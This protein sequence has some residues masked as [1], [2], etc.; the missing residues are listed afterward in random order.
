M[1]L[2]DPRSGEASVTLTFFSL[3]FVVCLAKL[4]LSGFSI[5]SVNFSLFSG[6]DFAA[7]V[8]ALGAVYAMRRSQGGSSEKPG[9]DS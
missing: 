5:G 8:G 1:W 7:A 9:Q 2:K 4:V 3:G 6:V